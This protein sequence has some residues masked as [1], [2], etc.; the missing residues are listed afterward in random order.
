M[1]FDVIIVGGSY[2]G[3]SAGLQLARA[4]QN[5]LVIDAGKRRNRFAA[6]SHGFLGQDGR[7]PGQIVSEARAQLER[8]P[9]VHW[10]NATVESAKRIAGGFAVYTG[11]GHMEKGRR[12]ILATGVVDRLPTI[13][14][15]QERWG[16]SVFHCPYCHGY[17][18]NQGRIGVI[19][20]SEL[21]MHHALMLPDWG[22]TTF[23]TNGAFAP[24]AEQLS[25]LL[26][27]GAAIEDTPI[28]EISG[29]RADVLLQDGRVVVMDGL[30]ALTRTLVQAPW[31]EELGCVLEEGPLGQFLKTDALKETTA[32]GVFA[33]GDVARAAGNVAL[34]VGDGAL[35]G[36]AT[37]RSLMFEAD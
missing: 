27:R 4:R 36:A 12:L 24:D 3:L 28:R 20:S 7:E 31:A 19:A 33:C 9:T 13:P 29:E 6:A 17:E 1:R 15:L 35:A 30:F 18:L 5:I 14:G 11:G 22:T 25:Q 37:H 32:K 23:F 2:A 8:Y 16:R 26:A 34:S 10:L 21:S